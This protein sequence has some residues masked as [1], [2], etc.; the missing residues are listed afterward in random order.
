MNKIEKLNEFL[1]DYT[2]KG[3]AT[4]V[5]DCALFVSNWALVVTGEDLAVPF[6]GRYKTDLGSARL[7]KKLG[8]KNLEDLVHREFD[9]VGK[10]RK[11]PLMAQRGDVAW[12]VGSQERVC[13]I[14]GAGGVLVLGVSGLVS[15]PL[16][17][18]V[19]AWEI[20]G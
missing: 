3:F 20:E 15:L 12:V 16:S 6:R 5:N 1:A 11:S 19:C 13:G 14:V 4:G 2:G 18:I 10:R 7:I 8:Y 17:S 9:R